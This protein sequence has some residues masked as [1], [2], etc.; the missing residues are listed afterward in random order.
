MNEAPVDR[1]TAIHA[2]VGASGAQLGLSVMT[3]IGVAI[4]W[5][6]LETPLKNE[7]PQLFPSPAPDSLLNSAIDVGAAV[8]G[9][10]LVR[11]L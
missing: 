6:I 1:Y 4:A 3:V 9:Y 10:C 2:L 11:S 7:F 8:A 5:E